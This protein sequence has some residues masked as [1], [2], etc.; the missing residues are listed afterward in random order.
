MGAERQRRVSSISNESKPLIRQLSRISAPKYADYFFI[1]PIEEGYI[2][3]SNLK[4]GTLTIFDLHY[5]NDLIE[6]NK[7]VSDTIRD[8]RILKEK[9][10]RGVNLYGR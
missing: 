6:Y 8:Y 9:T 1:R 2:K 3:Y 10:S 5:M 7:E 4:D